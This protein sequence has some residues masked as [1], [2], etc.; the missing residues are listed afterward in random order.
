MR[1]S[2]LGRTHRGSHARRLGRS[3][4]AVGAAI[5]WCAQDRGRRRPGRACRK[6]KETAPKIQLKKNMNPVAV[7]DVSSRCCGRQRDSNT[8]SS[9]LPHGT[10]PLLT[11]KQNDGGPWGSARS[12]L[13]QAGRGGIMAEAEGE[14]LE[15]WLS[16]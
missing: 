7:R 2:L 13:A 11:Q 15:S 9:E 16:E 5:L 10:E 8:G 12:A 6:E 14:S 1:R 4:T 3:P